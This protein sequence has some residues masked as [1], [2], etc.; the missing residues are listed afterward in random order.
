MENPIWDLAEIWESARPAA[1]WALALA[2]FLASCVAA[3]N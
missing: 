3:C 2:W 1:P